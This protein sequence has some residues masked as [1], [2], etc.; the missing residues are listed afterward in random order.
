VG[1]LARS[2]GNL[3]QKHP[4]P[5]QHK[6]VPGQPTRQPSTGNNPTQEEMRDYLAS[7]AKE[8]GL[9]TDLVHAVA[10]TES[11]FHPS[12]I[13]HNRAWKDKRGRIHPASNDLGLMQ[14]NEAKI[15]EPV[16][17]AK[18]HSFKIGKD[19]E[20]DWKANARAGVAILA[21]QYHLAELEQ[22]PGYSAQDRAQQ[23]YAGYNGGEGRRDRYLRERH[24]GLPRNDHDRHFLLNYQEERLKK[25]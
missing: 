15:G 16:K 20:T 21:G 23:A 9:P 12:K 10:Q 8:Y 18:G 25:K 11:S 4:H 3:L 5:E 2:L 6:P 22:G 1:H 7:Q 13:G 19:I 24:D 17:D 14:V